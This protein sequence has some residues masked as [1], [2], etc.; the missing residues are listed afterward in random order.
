MSAQAITTFILKHRNQ[1]WLLAAMLVAFAL[2]VY[3]LGAQS[4]WNDEG[5][6]VALAP[7]SLEAIANSAA[8]DIHPPLYYF[9]LH[10]WMPFIGNSEYAVRFLSVIAGVATVAL[11]SRV[12]YSVF[13]GRVAIV[14]AFLSAVSAFQV[15]YSQEARMYIWVTLWSAVSVYAMARMLEVR[16]WKLEVGKRESDS[17]TPISNLQSPISNSQSSNSRSRRRL[18]W[19]AY[20]AATIAALYTQYFAASIVVAEN[21]AFVVWLFF[22]WRSAVGGERSSVVGRAKRSTV[23]HSLAFWVAAQVIVGLA[24][25]PWY[26]S[27][28]EQLAS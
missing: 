16:S 11:V 17:A 19:L 18:F 1:F 8:H 20:I 12:A 2:R 25:A 10:F 5:N 15:Y 6:S 24:I 27:V 23:K 13:D 14:A 22:A 26:L 4:L 7:L 28:R 3:A 21:L 9:L